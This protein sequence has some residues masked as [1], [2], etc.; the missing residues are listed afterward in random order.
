MKDNQE[1]DGVDVWVLMQDDP[2]LLQS[3]LVDKSR[4]TRSKPMII[5]YMGAQGEIHEINNETAAKR[6]NE[7][8]VDVQLSSQE[9]EGKSSHRHQSYLESLEQ[10]GR[11]QQEKY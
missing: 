10:H 9:R 2:Q 3:L 8:S 6:S 11:Q 5:V 1:L 7:D 4:H